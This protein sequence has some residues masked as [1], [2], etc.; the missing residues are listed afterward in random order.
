[1]L[2]A[3]CDR[4]G[5]GRPA[6]T[7]GKEERRS[8]ERNGQREEGAGIA[9]GILIVKDGFEESGTAGKAGDFV[10][11]DISDEMEGDGGP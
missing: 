5:W 2:R 4:R 3:A 1:M 8:E 6:W 7:D 10:K 11:E 9:W